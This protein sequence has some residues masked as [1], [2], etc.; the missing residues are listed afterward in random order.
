[1]DETKK[2]DFD[3]VTILLE[4]YFMNNL[5]LSIFKEHFGFRKIF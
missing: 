3:N 4:D 5:L 2:F 1:V